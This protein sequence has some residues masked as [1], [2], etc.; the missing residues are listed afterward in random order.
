MS[1]RGADVLMFLFWEALNNRYREQLRRDELCGYS[2]IYIRL[3][4]LQISAT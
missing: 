1:G 3:S 2:N 4:A